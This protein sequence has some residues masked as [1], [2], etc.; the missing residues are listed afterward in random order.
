MARRT[1]SWACCRKAGPSIV[2][3]RRFEA[4][5]FLPSNMTRDFRWLGASAKLKPGMSL[6]PR[7]PEWTCRAASAGAHPDS[8]RGWSASRWTDSLTC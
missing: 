4:L 3:P 2:R 7:G 6:E 1:P 5:A 8:N